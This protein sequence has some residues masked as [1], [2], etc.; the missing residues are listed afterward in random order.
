MTVRVEVVYE[1]DLHCVATHGPSGDTITTDAPV[2]N[3]GKG[4][5]FEWTSGMKS[6]V[7]VRGTVD[8]RGD[9]DKGWS[10]EIAIPLADVKGM[11]AGM[12]V[13][14]PPVPGDRW[15]LNVVRVDLPKGQSGVSA[16][17][18]SPITIRDFHAL[19]RMLNV[20]FADADGQIPGKGTVAPAAADA[21]PP[22]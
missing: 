8:Q 7:N 20:E 14:I 17:S 5:H 10:A 21:A 19:G 2:D 12:K 13:T 4:E 1:G 6:A 3:R 16:S 22:G 18:W 11:E 9:R 15:R